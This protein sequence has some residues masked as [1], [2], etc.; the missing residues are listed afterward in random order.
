MNSPKSKLWLGGNSGKSLFKLLVSVLVNT[1]R[2]L[3][4]RLDGL[5]YFTI[6]PVCIKFYTRSYFAWIREAVIRA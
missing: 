1:W 5:G 6:F 4:A 3:G 2:A